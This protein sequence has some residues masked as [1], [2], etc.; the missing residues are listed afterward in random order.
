MMDRTMATVAVWITLLHLTVA[1]LVASSS[2]S[3]T[4]APS[5]APTTTAPTTGTTPAPIS[6][7]GGDCAEPLTSYPTATCPVQGDL[8]GIFRTPRCNNGVFN[9]ELVRR[10]DYGGPACAACLAHN[11]FYNH[12]DAMRGACMHA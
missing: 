8:D 12:S 10:T 5:T 4:A 6:S 2:P 9:S 1:V 11:A 3:P 7:S